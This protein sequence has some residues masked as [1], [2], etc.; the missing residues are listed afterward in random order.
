MSSLV[1]SSSSFAGV[2]AGSQQQQHDGMAGS[3]QQ[4]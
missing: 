1:R 2:H 4:A 3:S